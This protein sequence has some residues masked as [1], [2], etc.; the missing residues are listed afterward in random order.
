MRFDR[1]K[2]YDG[3]RAWRGGVAPGQVAGLNQLLDFIEKDRY[4]TDIRWPSYML[5]TVKRETD[6]TYHPIH[7]YGGH[8]YFV[9]RYGGHTR[10]GRELGNDTPEEGA[11]YAGEGYPQTTGESNYEKAEDA[12]RKYYPEVVRDFEARTGRKFDLTVGDQPNDKKDPRNMGDPAIAYYTMSH[13]MRTG[14]FTGRSLSHY[15]NATREDPYNARKIINGLDH[16]SEIAGDYW[17]FKKILT[18]ALIRETTPENVASVIDAQTIQPSPV[19]LQPAVSVSATPP[20]TLPIEQTDTPPNPPAEGQPANTLE[21]KTLN[22]P[23]AEGSVSTSTKMT[24]LGIGVPTFL[25]GAVSAFKQAIAE[26][27]VNTQQV[28]DALLGFITTNTKYFLILIGAIIG[29]L[30]VKKVCKQVTFWIQM[31]IQSDPTRHD[32]EIKPQ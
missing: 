14:M 26:G 20:D 19:E 7:E 32:V 28:G 30:V 21:T 13:G 22:A 29:L 27:Y 3:F 18:N 12:L 16:A 9:R 17:Q 15:F 5:T 11:D 1:K 4:L 6:S 10:K 8:D 23:A 25:T 24:L 31:W 2:F